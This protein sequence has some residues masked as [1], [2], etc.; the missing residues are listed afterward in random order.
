MLFVLF[1]VLVIFIVMS[2]VVS[3]FFVVKVVSGLSRLCKDLRR[4]RVVSVRLICCRS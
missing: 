4:V 3:V 2:F 1:F